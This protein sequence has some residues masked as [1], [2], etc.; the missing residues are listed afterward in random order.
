[1][2]MRY[3]DTLNITLMIKMPYVLQTFALEKFK[4]CIQS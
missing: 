1:M 2:T 3:S 4:T